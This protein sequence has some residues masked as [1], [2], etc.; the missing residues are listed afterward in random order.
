MLVYL[1]VVLRE[2]LTFFFGSHCC[3]CMICLVKQTMEN[4]L[5]LKTIANELTHQFLLSHF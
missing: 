4:M 3:Q 1:S 2:T 5:Q